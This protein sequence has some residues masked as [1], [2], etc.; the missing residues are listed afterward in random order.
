VVRLAWYFRAGRFSGFT[1]EALGLFGACNGWSRRAVLFGGIRK[2]VL[3][4]MSG[5]FCVCVGEHALRH[6]GVGFNTGIPGPSCPC[7]SG[8]VVVSAVFRR[9]GNG[10]MCSIHSRHGAW[11]HV[12]PASWF[13]ASVPACRRVSQNGASGQAYAGSAVM[14][15]VPDATAVSGVS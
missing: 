8:V 13:S 4:G 9:N 3:R 12:P 15:Y 14:P 11:H 10:A 1:T 2:A 5:R 7:A 6:G